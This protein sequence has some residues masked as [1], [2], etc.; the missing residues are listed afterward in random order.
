[1]TVTKKSPSI[2]VSRRV[3]VSR[4]GAVTVD[5]AVLHHSKSYGGVLGGDAGARRVE[6]PSIAA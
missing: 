5:P 2:A 3:A 4:G 6:S 1:V